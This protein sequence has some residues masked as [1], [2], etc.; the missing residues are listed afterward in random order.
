LLFILDCVS[1][2]EISFFEMK[3]KNTYLYSDWGIPGYFFFRIF[4]PKFK[5]NGT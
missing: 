1:V 5:Q 3:P 4:A 2:I